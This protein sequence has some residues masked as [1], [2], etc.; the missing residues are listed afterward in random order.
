MPEELKKMDREEKRLW[1]AGMAMQGLLAGG[2]M[3]DVADR[4]AALADRLMEAL[5]Q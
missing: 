2:A 3:L 4:A 1:L 5:G